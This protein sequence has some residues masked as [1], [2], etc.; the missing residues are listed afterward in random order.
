MSSS[1]RHKLFEHKIQNPLNK[2]MG[3]TN[4]EHEPPHYIPQPHR[5]QVYDYMQKVNVHMKF[6]KLWHIFP[7]CFM[8]C[9]NF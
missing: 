2:I 5:R 8:F 7:P 3:P 6:G 9:G 1:R 4:P